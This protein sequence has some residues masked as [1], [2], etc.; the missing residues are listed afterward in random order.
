MNNYFI[1]ADF[2]NLIDGTLSPNRSPI[3]TIKS[4]DTVTIETVSM[5][6][7]EGK[8]EDYLEKNGYKLTDTPLFEK[9]IASQELIPP[10]VHSHT[11]TGPIYI[12]EAK[13]GDVLELHINNIELTTP[14]ANA[15][16]RPGAGGLPDMVTSVQYFMAKFNEAR[17]HAD[18]I[19]E[20]LPL[21]P[22]F[23]IMGNAPTELAPSGP[24][25]FCGGNLDC[26]ELVAGTTLYL[27]IAVDGA[28]FYAGD[29]HAAQGDGEVSVT[30][31]ETSL[32]GTFT[33]KIRKDMHLEMPFA[34]TLNDYLFLAVAKTLDEAMRI[35]LK[36]AVD[37]IMEHKQLDFQSALALASIICDLR[38]TQVV[39]GTLGV[40]AVL[41]KKYFHN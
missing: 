21:N 31:L 17:T 37:F 26:K 40:H 8:F 34:E 20:S 30:A 7:V 3:L 27:P 6:G 33:F 2:K 12:E 28:L 29:G 9:I 4:G 16:V 24:P 19:G 25:Q 35:A 10:L 11:L 13:A 38:I 22:F 14:F 18:F 39:N 23:G 15:R 32:T 5:I 1:S 41:P 36:S